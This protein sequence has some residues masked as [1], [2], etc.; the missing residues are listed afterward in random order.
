MTILIL[1]L[2]IAGIGTGSFLWIKSLYNKNKH[3][4]NKL[5]MEINQNIQI[6]KNITEY[7]KIIVK[8]ND[9]DK[10]IEGLNEKIDNATSSELI[11]YANEL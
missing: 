5:E 2:V 3:L 11:S 1:S 7:K 6:T 8:L 10:Y 9:K 4:E